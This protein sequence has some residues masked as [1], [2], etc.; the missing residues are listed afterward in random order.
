MLVVDSRS[1]SVFHDVTDVNKGQTKGK[2]QIKILRVTSL[3]KVPRVSPVF[4]ERVVI[5]AVLT[6]IV[7]LLFGFKK[8]IHL[9]ILIFTFFV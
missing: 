1:S 6:K 3:V 8:L 9:S 4:K 2:E 7:K 5:L